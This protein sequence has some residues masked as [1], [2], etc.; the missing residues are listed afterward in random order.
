MGT[1]LPNNF[2]QYP[3]VNTTGCN[4]DGVDPTEILNFLFKKSL[5]IPNT[6]PHGDFTSELYTWNS[7]LN[8]DNKTLYSQKIPYDASDIGR[9]IQV[10]FSNIGYPNDFLTSFIDSLSSKYI[11]S[12]YPYIAL[13]SNVLMVPTDNG[14]S[15]TFFC[16]NT[17]NQSFINNTSFSKNAIPY[18]YGDG[19]IYNHIVYLCNG[20]FPLSPLNAQ[21]GGSWILDTDSGVITFYDTVTNG[22]IDNS[23]PPRIT[24]WRYEGLTGNS[25]IVNVGSY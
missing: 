3:L 16:G 20:I 22:I 13:Y 25:G 5:G 23:N 24:F 21:D 19:L 18:Y 9:L 2:F 8:V 17:N 1:P 11:S 15:N 12:N 7:I 4:S 6:R 10:P 14:N